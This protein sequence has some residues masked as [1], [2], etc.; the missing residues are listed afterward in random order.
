M[1]MHGFVRACAAGVN[2]SFANHRCSCLTWSG[3]GCIIGLREIFMLSLGTII[4]AH[5]ETFTD[6]WT[7]APG[8]LSGNGKCVAESGPLRYRCLVSVQDGKLGLS[9][10]IE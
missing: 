8:D 7:S 10:Q 1:R 9:L 5:A 6:E 2:V 3:T 4:D